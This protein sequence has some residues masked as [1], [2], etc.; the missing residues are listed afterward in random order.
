MMEN[1]KNGARLFGAL[2][3]TIG[4]VVFGWLGLGCIFLNVILTN[5]TDVLNPWSIRNTTVE[6]ES[7]EE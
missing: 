7:V 2:A 6:S 1:F 3:T 5:L 4:A